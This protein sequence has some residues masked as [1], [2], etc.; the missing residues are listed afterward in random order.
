MSGRCLKGARKVSGFCLGFES[1]LVDVWKVSGRHQEGLRKV[2]GGLMEV[3]GAWKVSGI[4]I[5]T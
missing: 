2:S 4:R 3:E 5:L 1:F